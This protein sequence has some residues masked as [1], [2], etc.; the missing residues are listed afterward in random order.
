MRIALYARVS[1]TDQHTENQL[2]ELRR[3]AQAREWTTHRE[4]VDEGV[5][6]AKESRPAGVVQSKPSASETNATPRAWR[7]SSKRIR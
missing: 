3:Y 7:S 5:S 4:Y 6:G 2:V 1:T